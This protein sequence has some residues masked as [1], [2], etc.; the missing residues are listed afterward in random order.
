MT[1]RRAIVGGLLVALLAV[2][3]PSAQAAGEVTARIKTATCSRPSFPFVV[4]NSTSR[5]RKFTVVLYHA[6]GPGEHLFLRDRVP[7]HGGM[8]GTVNPNWNT[9][10]FWVVE[11]FRTWEFKPWSNYWRQKTWLAGASARLSCPAP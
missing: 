3:I 1:I 8:Q 9:R 4:E 10:D 11:I 7:A 2:C 6:S 5:Y